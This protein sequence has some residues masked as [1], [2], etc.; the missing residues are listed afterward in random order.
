MLL[1]K[2]ISEDLEFIV[3]EKSLKEP[4]TYYIQGPYL[5]AEK[6]NR[7]KRV[8]SLNEMTNEV[9][10]YKREFITTN[11]ALGELN[12]PLDSTEVNL[13]RACHMIVSLEQKDNNY[14]W[15]K[16][17]ILST[18]A[19]VIVRQLLSDG[20]KLGISSRA[21][22]KLIPRGDTNLVEGLKLIALDLVHLPSVEEAMLDSIMESR[23]YIIQEGGKIVELA[24]DS[25]QCRLN[26]LPKKDVQ[27]HLKES[28]DKFIQDLKK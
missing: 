8:Y 13:E 4:S 7:N 9:D 26:T 23:Q 20:C 6:P 16:S 22:G 10:K 19:G 5:M 25:L 11:R 17:K 21:L 15:G 12:H 18:P 24:C 1:E 2:P 28:F 14:F 3:E 27:K